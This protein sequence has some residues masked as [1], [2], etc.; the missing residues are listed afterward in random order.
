MQAVAVKVHRTKKKKRRTKV[1]LFN[2][3]VPYASKEEFLIN[4]SRLPYST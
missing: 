4:F 3:I 2:A 1:I